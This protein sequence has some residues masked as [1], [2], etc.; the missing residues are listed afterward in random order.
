MVDELIAG[1][2]LGTSTSAI[3][4]FS[5]NRIKSYGEVRLVPGEL[6]INWIYSAEVFDRTRSEWVVGLQARNMGLRPDRAPYCVVSAKRHLGID[7]V[8]EL[9]EGAERSSTITIDGTAVDLTPQY[10]LSI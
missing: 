3:G 9:G 5:E 4:Y 2:D 10:L 7:R 8:M 6:G 1:I